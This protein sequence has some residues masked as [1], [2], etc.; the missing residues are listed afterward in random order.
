[1]D[2][3]RRPALNRRRSG[4]DVKRVLQ[5]AG[6][7]LRLRFA[8]PAGMFEDGD[9]ATTRDLAMSRRI[10]VERAT[11]TDAADQ[12]L[13][14]RLMTRRGELGPLGHPTY[15]SRHHELIGQPNIERTRNLIKLH[16]LEA[17]AGEARVE[18]VLRCE[19][20]AATNPPRDVVRIDLTLRIIGEP[21]E[22]NLVVPFNLGASIGTSAAG[23]RP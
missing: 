19:V 14:N 7:D 5:L 12:F 8:G 17:L 23:A 3:R 21:S 6:T 9:L 15:G 2:D 18:R 4:A 16:V 20:R 22:R 11:G 13:V 1:M 10:D